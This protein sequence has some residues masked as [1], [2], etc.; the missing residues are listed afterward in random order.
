MRKVRGCALP[1]ELHYHL[2][3]NVWVVRDAEGI[4]HLGFTAYACAL[5]G[6]VVAYT[7]KAAGRA[8]ARDRSCATLESG[9]WVGPVKTP[10]GG[11]LVEVNER[12]QR[13]PYIIN[14]DPYGDGWLVR[15]RP[16]D[17]DGDASAL[18]TGDLARAGFEA[19]MQAEGFDGCL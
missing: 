19:K 1:E 4:A 11:V 9:K 8:V 5:A 6:P 14:Q 2:D 12:A 17:W 15:L 3:H 18:L 13:E 10:V 16:S 7:P